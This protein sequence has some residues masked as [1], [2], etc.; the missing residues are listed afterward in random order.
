MGTVGPM[1]RR[2]AS[3]EP[4][5]RAGRMPQ[6]VRPWTDKP[7]PRRAEALFLADSNY[8]AA[9]SIK[10][11]G[12]LTSP[13]CQGWQNLD[14]PRT[15][16]EKT[17]REVK[18]RSARVCRGS[19]IAGIQVRTGLRKTQLGARGYRFP[20]M[21]PVFMISATELDN[22]PNVPGL[23]RNAF[24]ARDAA[25]RSTLNLGPLVHSPGAPGWIS[26]PAPAIHEV[27]ALMRL[28][29]PMG[30]SGAD[31]TT[32]PLAACGPMVNA[33]ICPV[34]HTAAGRSI[35]KRLGAAP[36]EGQ[37]LQPTDVTDDQGKKMT[38]PAHIWVYPPRSTP[39][40][41]LKGARETSMRMCPF[42]GDL[43]RGNDA[44]GA[45]NLCD[46]CGIVMPAWGSTLNAA[47]HRVCP[48]AEWCC[49]IARALLSG[50]VYN[51]RGGPWPGAVMLFS[52]LVGEVMMRTAFDHGVPHCGPEHMAGDARIIS[53]LTPEGRGRVSG[54]PN[55]DRVV[56]APHPSTHP[57][58][59]TP[60]GIGR[61]AIAAVGPGAPPAPP[62][63]AAAASLVCPAGRWDRAVLGY[64]PPS[65]SQGQTIRRTTAAIRSITILHERIRSR[66]MR[67]AMFS[68]RKF[69]RPELMTRALS[70]CPLKDLM[71]EI[72]TDLN[73]A[74]TET[75]LAARPGPAADPTFVT[76]LKRN[77]A[78]DTELIF[79]ATGTVTPKRCS[80]LRKIRQR[81][82]TGHDV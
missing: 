20:H 24:L 13:A 5:A 16:R 81:F 25:P 32:P 50:P 6:V 73:R 55:G 56:S 7:P 38:T 44:K 23:G 59:T 53:P 71:H 19:A 62:S 33:G 9:R 72:V 29:A 27:V 76:D 11:P 61:P 77:R 12:I 52:M 35:C 18:K 51:R 45:G 43:R 75:L 69:T 3:L 15:N 78:S 17:A 10:T 63:L 39:M 1:S 70:G 22:G 37:V 40:L 8:R 48:T 64:V 34:L 65:G 68:G 74:A 4:D 2:S 21:H 57:A 30:T 28:C 66:S 41:G 14:P 47:P 42:C 58:P 79:A 49:A 80:E 31:G 46:M 26:R 82:P 67:R 54:V 60:G 36:R